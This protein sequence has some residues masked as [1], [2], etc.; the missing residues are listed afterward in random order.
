MDWLGEKIK[1]L[2]KENNISIVKLAEKIGVSRQTV[3]DWINGQVPKGSHLINLCKLFN[4]NPDYFFEDGFN[5]SITVPVHR[6]RRAAKVTAKMQKDAVSLAREYDLL[7]RNDTD[8]GILPVMRG[9]GRDEKTTQKVANALR[10]RAG[11]SNEMPPDYGHAFALM[12]NLGIK[13]IFRN[14]PQKIKA[15]AFY[16]K[17]HNHR[18]VFVNNATNI[19]D[20]IFPLLHESV[21]AVR[22]EYRVNDGFD[23]EEE[24]FC[25]NVSNHIQ[26][27]DEY[28]RM[29]YTVIKDLK[30]AI[31]INKLKS[32]GEQYSH[33]LFGLVKRIQN[34]D[35][36][37]SLSIGGADTNLKKRFPAIGEILF[38]EK[39]PR[40]YVKILAELSPL[41]VRTII[42]QLDGLTDRKLGELLGIDTV[43][44]A[45]SIKAELLR[46]KK[47]DF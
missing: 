18:I 25:D 47:A 14:F 27:P 42:S 21:H 5:D 41:F 28:V 9:H 10:T 2:I 24:L 40:D 46:L 12:E 6:T 4:I 39:E 35:P 15:Y 26:F 44:D 32:F 38:G 11:I 43:M 31:Q 16:T 37:F 36:S 19:L 23:E 45:K 33:A 8:V 29:V 1:D 7:F 20:L 30:P 22:D 17:I 3:N 34:I 13:I